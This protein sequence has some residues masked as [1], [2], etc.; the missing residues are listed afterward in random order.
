VSPGRAR[1]AS[2]HAQA[3]PCVRCSC[4]R[5]SS[6]VEHARPVLLP[7]VVAV[8]FTLMLAPAVRKL[9]RLGVT[10]AIGAALVVTAVLAG[11]ALIGL[12]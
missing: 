4:W 7:I 2:L 1:R 6:P 12:P 5:S 3:G 11:L 9:R 10:E 8:V